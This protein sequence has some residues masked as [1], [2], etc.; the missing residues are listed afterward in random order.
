MSQSRRR[1][2]SNGRS[3]GA[4]GMMSENDMTSLTNYSGAAFDRMFLEMMIQHHRGAVEM[5]QTE[6]RDGRYGPAE[7]NG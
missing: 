5:A 7:S 3:D 6:L 1:A 4:G 2:G